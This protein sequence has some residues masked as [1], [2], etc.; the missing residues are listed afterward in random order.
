MSEEFLELVDHQQN[1]LVIAGKA[2]AEHVDQTIRTCAK[3]VL[4]FIRELLGRCDGIFRKRCHDL[5][6]QRTDRVVSRQHRDRGRLIEHA[7]RIVR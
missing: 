4:E 6:G 1:V 5:I 3:P 7:A 2:A